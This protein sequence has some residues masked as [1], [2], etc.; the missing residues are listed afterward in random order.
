MM[1]LP[2][3]DPV[4]PPVPPDAAAPWPRISLVTPSFNQAAYL[5]RCLESVL[6]QSYPNLEW[7]VFDG[8]STDASPDIIRRHSRHFAFWHIGPD[9][10]QSDAIIRG[11]SMATGDI[12]AW[13]NSDDFYYPD[14]LMHVARAFTDNPQLVMLCGSVAIVDREERLLRL[15]R[16]PTVSAASLLPW[17]PVPGQPATFI[18]RDVV[19]TLGAPRID[20]HYVLDWEFWLRIALAYPESRLARTD[21]ILAGSREWEGTKTSTAA[22]RD[23]AEV[24]RVLDELFRQADLPPPLV[25]L[26][27][28]ALAR[29]WWR[30]SQSERAAG[31]CRQAFASL[32]RAL[33]LSPRQFPVAAVLR[34][35]ARIASGSL[36]TG[37]RALARPG[38]PEGS[39]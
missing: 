11:W 1:T 13:L 10:G 39:S 30:Q 9:R 37:A 22:G 6:S 25:A 18:R 16:P 35:A 12:L 7:L 28:Q 21:R 17:G 27:R 32:V 19:E 3:Q 33:R 8:G 20:L 24:R 14:A 29:S 38:R 23:A 15:K 31:A 26:R 34:H 5:E 2:P 36:S 4:P